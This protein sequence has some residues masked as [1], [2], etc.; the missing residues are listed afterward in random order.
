MVYNFF[1]IRI[2]R[3]ITIQAELGIISEDYQLA[4]EFPGSITRNFWKNSWDKTAHT[5]LGI[6]SKDHQLADELT[7]LAIH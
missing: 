1:L 6:I 7:K 5:G 4:N 2:S 3:D